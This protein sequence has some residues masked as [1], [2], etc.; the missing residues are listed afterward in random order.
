CRSN[1]T[2]QSNMGQYTC[3]ELAERYC[4]TVD[5]FFLL[6]PLLDPHCL[7]IQASE[8]HWVAGNIVP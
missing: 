4:L 3:T 7:S 8:E 1:A 2:A 5:H 6:N